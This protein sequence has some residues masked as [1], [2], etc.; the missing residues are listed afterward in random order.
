MVSAYSPG[1]ALLILNMFA[2]TNF[3][4]P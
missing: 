4:N 2:D 1:F 3:R